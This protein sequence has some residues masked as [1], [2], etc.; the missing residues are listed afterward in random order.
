MKDFSLH[1]VF[2]RIPFSVIQ[3]AFTL[4]KSYAKLENLPRF[5]SLA[6]SSIRRHL[7][8]LHQLDRP[9][10]I[11]SD[12]LVSYPKGTEPL[13]PELELSKMGELWRDRE[14]DLRAQLLSAQRPIH[15][16]RKPGS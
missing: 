13:A 1:H 10:T 12:K 5:M 2:A 16:K 15:P 3:L 11:S 6:E 9:L 7:R 4:T 8:M 14:S